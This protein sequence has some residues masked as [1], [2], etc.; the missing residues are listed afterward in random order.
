MANQDPTSVVAVPGAAGSG[1]ATV[2]WTQPV[3]GAPLKYSIRV[4]NP[5]T[6]FGAVVGTFPGTA[7]SQTIS[8]LTP[9][10]SIQF[11][12]QTNLGGNS[13]PSSAVTIPASPSTPSGGSGATIKDA[14]GNIAIT[15]DVLQ[16]GV[17]SSGTFGTGSGVV[18]VLTSNSAGAFVGNFVPRT[19]SLTTFNA[20]VGNAGEIASVNGTGGPALFQFSGTAPGGVPFYPSPFSYVTSNGSTNALVSSTYS[21]VLPTTPPNGLFSIQPN[22]NTTSILGT[23]A[24][25]ATV[26]GGANTISG[27][28][29]AGASAINGISP[30]IVGQKNSIGYGYLGTPTISVNDGST[31]FGSFNIDSWGGSQIPSGS[32]SV[33]VGGN[34]L[35]GIANTVL[36]ANSGMLV[37]NS[38][39]AQAN[40]PTTVGTFPAFSPFIFGSFNAFTVTAKP[41][42]STYTA[43]P[44]IQPMLIGGSNTANAGTYDTLSLVGQYNTSTGAIENSMATGHGISFGPIANTHRIGHGFFAGAN[45]YI[46]GIDFVAT[47]ATSGVVH[48]GVNTAAAANGVLAG[49]AAGTVEAGRVAVSHTQIDGSFGLHAKQIKTTVAGADSVTVQPNVSRLRITGT[50]AVTSETITLPTTPAEGQIL[51]INNANTLT[52]TTVIFAGGTVTNSSTV[53]ALLAPVN[54]HIVL[55]YD[56]TAGVWDQIA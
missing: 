14:S 10:E 48:I 1:Q 11:I 13:L 49:P 7:V 22:D 6:G 51:S 15:G 19:G 44:Y 18:G 40:I 33:T 8:G 29:G 31:L 39:N 25:F 50:A 56:S 30:T 27:S 16:G 35:V 20:T 34:L 47:S 36:G 2:S 54:G 28:T 26:F 23:A 12:V 17:A 42:T 5:L 32:P 9:G 38:N 4:I 24:N 41:A 55:S 21:G 43:Q 52:L 3:S 53:A 46:A 45:S 37:G